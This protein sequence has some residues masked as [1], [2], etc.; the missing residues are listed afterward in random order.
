MTKSLHDLVFLKENLK[1]TSTVGIVG[2]EVD[3]E[4]EMDKVMFRASFLF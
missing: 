2:L 4:G 3:L 1:S